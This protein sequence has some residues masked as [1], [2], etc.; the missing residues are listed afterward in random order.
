MRIIL[1]NWTMSWLSCSQGSK[2]CHWVT[3]LYGN[4]VISSWF[5]RAQFLVRPHTYINERFMLHG[6]FIF[7]GVISIFV[8]ITKT[9]KDNKQRE[10]HEEED[11]NSRHTELIT[12]R[13][14]TVVLLSSATFQLFT[15]NLN[16][17]LVIFWTDGLI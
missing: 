5:F 9:S 10:K 3:E 16:Q 14:H 17:E 7:L 2:S 12:P 1:I 13:I 15:S 6:F 8:Y 4:V 11:T